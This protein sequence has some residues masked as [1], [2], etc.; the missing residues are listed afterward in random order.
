ML[1]VKIN[2]PWIEEHLTVVAKANGKSPEEFVMDTIA[3]YLEDL[4]DYE[5]C[6]RRMADIRSGKT[7]TISSVEMERRLGL[8]H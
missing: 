2:D 7:K 6:E 5:E 3:E 1:A 8:A 4:E